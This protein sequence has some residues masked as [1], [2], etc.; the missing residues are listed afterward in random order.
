L[1]SIFTEIVENAT[2]NQ[3]I[4]AEKEY[5]TLKANPRTN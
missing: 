2:D 5:I 4:F 3:I 1:E